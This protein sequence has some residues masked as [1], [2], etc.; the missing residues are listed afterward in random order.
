MKI[1]TL[2]QPWATLVALGAKHIETRSWSTNYR[3][4]LAIHAGAGLAGMGI[5]EYAAL[6][7]AMYFGAALRPRY[8]AAGIMLRDE[9]NRLYYKDPLPRGA[10]AAVAELVDCVPTET[11]AYTREIGRFTAEGHPRIWQ[12]TPQ[13]YAF[14]DYSLG[15][16]AWLI[17]DV[18]RLAEPL[19]YRGG[20][21]LRELPADVV[22]Q[23]RA[24]LAVSSGPA[25]R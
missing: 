7:R 21:G 25:A 14:G 17:A 16:Y 5:Q 13:E 2:T 11:L 3:G 22:A 18:R 9:Q 15:R 23:I 10:I 4:L 20:L 12:M 24:Q 1:L 6:C 8:P 19:P